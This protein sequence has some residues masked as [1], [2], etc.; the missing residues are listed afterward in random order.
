M[1]TAK[2]FRI[3]ETPEEAV[4]FLGSDF[5]YIDGVEMDKDGR[6]LSVNE[7]AVIKLSVHDLLSAFRWWSFED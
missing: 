7:D 6:V 2:E 5:L 3:P 4:E 1:R